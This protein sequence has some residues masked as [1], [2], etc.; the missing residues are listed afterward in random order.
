VA[1]G[2][3]G[4]LEPVGDVRFGLLGEREKQ[5]AAFLRS[6]DEARQE[7]EGD[8]YSGRTSQRPRWIPLGAGVRVTAKQDAR[9]PAR[10]A[11]RDRQWTCRRCRWTSAEIG[12]LLSYAAPL[13]RWLGCPFNPLVGTTINRQLSSSASTSVSTFSTGSRAPR[14]A[15]T[16]VSGIVDGSRSMIPS[17]LKKIEFRSRA[18]ASS[19][20]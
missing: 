19:F 13:P 10:R 17:F 1:F 5:R 2:S 14:A 15:S 18:S 4:G 8:R 16:T 9:D 6:L 20:A 11:R 7:I 12:R 3:H